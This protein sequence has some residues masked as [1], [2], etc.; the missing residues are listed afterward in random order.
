MNWDINI[1]GLGD[2]AT[3]DEIYRFLTGEPFMKLSTHRS[4]ALAALRENYGSASEAEVVELF[5][6]FLEQRGFTATIVR[7]TPKWRAGDVIVY[8]FPSSAA[9]YTYVRGS[10]S[11]PG[12]ARSLTDAEVDGAYLEGRVRPVLQ[13]GGKPFDVARLSA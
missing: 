5:R 8:T 3:R 12:Q 11:W 9:E 2:R 10:S 6:A 13:G 4:R 7:H 1:G